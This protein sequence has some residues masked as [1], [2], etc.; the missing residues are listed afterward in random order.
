LAYKKS[1]GISLVSRDIRNYNLTLEPRGAT[2]SS[3][4]KRIETQHQKSHKE[5]YHLSVLGYHHLCTKTLPWPVRSERL[6]EETERLRVENP[7]CK[8]LLNEIAVARICV[9][10]VVARG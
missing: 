6:L 1:L 2:S 10:E 3:P 8:E 7:K 9:E 4:L 5:E